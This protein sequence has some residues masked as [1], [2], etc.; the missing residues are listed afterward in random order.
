MTAKGV[1]VVSAPTSRFRFWN[2]RRAST[3]R[4]CGSIGSAARSPMLTSTVSRN[5]NPFAQL[6]LE[7]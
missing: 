6:R 5:L 7:V 1:L 4:R 3:S 2:S